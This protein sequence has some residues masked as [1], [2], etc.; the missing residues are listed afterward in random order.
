MR[1]DIVPSFLLFLSSDLKLLPV[2]MLH[3]IPHAERESVR[4]LAFTN[5]VVEGGETNEVVSHLFD[6]F[7]GDRKPK[8]LLRDGEVEPEVPPCVVSVLLSKQ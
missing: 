8:L 3:K 2:Q 5:G 4:S 6:G 7:I 1:H